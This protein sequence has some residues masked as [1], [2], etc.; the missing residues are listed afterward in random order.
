MTG[1]VVFVGFA[2]AG[3]PGLSAWVC[4]TALAGFGLGSRALDDDRRR[5]LTTAATTETAGKR[6]PP[7][8]RIASVSAMLAGALVGAALVLHTSATWAIALAAGALALIALAIS[9][10][11]D[12]ARPI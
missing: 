1:N 7:W 4:L 10:A 5:W 9:R 2:I 6:T 11:G 3:A 8:R 12:L